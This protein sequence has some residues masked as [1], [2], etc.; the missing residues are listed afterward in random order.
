LPIFSAVNSI[1]HKHNLLQILF[2]IYYPKR[3]VT[4]SAIIPK[5][6]ITANIK[7]SLKKCFAITILL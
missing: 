7:R 2:I 4:K 3:F 6:I 1:Y 5:I